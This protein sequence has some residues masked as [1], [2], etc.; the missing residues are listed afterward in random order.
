M[1]C[2]QRHRHRLSAQYPGP[3]VGPRFGKD[4]GRQRREH[5]PIIAV[6]L[7]FKL[8]GCP[9]GIAGENPDS[10]DRGADR[11]RIRVEVNQDN[12]A[13]DVAQ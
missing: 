1:R 12:A 9:P 3:Q 10:V 5:D 2:P 6:D 4:V 13:G 11:F 8:A 7:A